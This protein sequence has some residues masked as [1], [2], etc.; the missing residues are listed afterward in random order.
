MLR[1]EDTN[2]WNQLLE[3]SRTQPV[4]VFKHSTNCD[5]SSAALEGFREFCSGHGL[6]SCA[7]VYVV[8]DRE[9]SNTIGREMG[10]RHESPQVIAI[11]G[12]RPIWHASH[13]H[14]DMEK[15]TEVLRDDH[16]TPEAS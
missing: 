2:D 9:L 7:V 5:I 13:W 11:E 10:V 14:I 12:R 15:L 4:V 8:E 16:R 6:I 3:S 1:L